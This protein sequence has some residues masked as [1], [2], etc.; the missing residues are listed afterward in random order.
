MRCFNR[1][2]QNNFISNRTLSGLVV[3]EAHVWRRPVRVLQRY[4]LN[5]KCLMPECLW[6]PGGPSESLFIL[7]N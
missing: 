5:K 4:E 6:S 7:G 1:N 3:F 2:H